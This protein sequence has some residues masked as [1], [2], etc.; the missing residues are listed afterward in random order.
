MKKWKIITDKDEEVKI[1]EIAP[2]TYLICSG[3]K[4]TRVTAEMATMFMEE[5]R[6][7]GYRI[8]PEV[9]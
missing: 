6:R 8:V 2:D 9:S 4:C 5:A 1:E 7:R 3:D